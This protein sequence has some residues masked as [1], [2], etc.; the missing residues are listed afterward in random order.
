LTARVLQEAD[1]LRAAIR[2][3]GREISDAHP[4]GILLVA[5]LKGSV[6]FLADLVREITVPVE[7]DFLGISSY[8]PGSGRVRLTKDLGTDLDGR[9]VILVEDVVDTGLTLAYLLT[10]LR[11]RGPSRLEVCTLFD[12]QARRIVPQTLAYV[13]FE[14]GDEFVVG[15][16][17]DFRGRYRN[18]D[19]VAAGDLDTLAADPDA[20]VTQL[21]P[22]GADS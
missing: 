21:Y 9:E 14:I 2:R 10:Q 17:L 7:I 16:G 13:G 3:L 19:L 22:S 4:D 20:Y 1:D 11:A 18:L 6:L 8:E 12:K 5:V 15:Y